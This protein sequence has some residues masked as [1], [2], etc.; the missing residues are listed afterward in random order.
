[1]I[2][3]LRTQTLKVAPLRGATLRVWE[4][5][6]YRY[7]SLVMKIFSIAIVENLK[8]NFDKSLSSANFRQNSSLK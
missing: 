3:Y 1:M 6:L 8:K 4:F 5:I 7:L 2:N